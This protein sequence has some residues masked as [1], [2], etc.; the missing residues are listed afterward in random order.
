MRTISLA[1]LLLLSGCY[2]PYGYGGYPYY[3]YG[4]GGPYPGGYP[5]PGA[6]PYPAAPSQYQPNSYT[7]NGPP[8]YAGGQQSPYGGAP[9]LQHGIPGPLDQQ[10]CGTPYE[11]KPCGG[12]GSVA[13]T[14]H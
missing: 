14:W 8:P 1:C 12:A 11:P 3:G 2:Y 7:P 9:Q 6:S 4:Y 10:N 5:Y 13:S